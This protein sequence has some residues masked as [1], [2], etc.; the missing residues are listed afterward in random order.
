M[1]AGNEV[2]GWK[3]TRPSIGLRPT[4]PIR[5]DSEGSTLTLRTKWSWWWIVLGLALTRSIGR[6]LSA[7]LMQHRR[8]E[9]PLL[10]LHWNPPTRWAARLSATIVEKKNFRFL[11]LIERPCGCN[12]LMFS[13]MG[14]KKRCAFALSSKDS[15]FSVMWSAPASD[16]S[17]TVDMQGKAGS[18]RLFSGKTRLKTKRLTMTHSPPNAAFE[19]SKAWPQR[20]NLDVFDLRISKRG[21]ILRT[22]LSHTASSWIKSSFD[23]YWSGISSREK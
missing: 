15:A 8:Q 7:C 13:M 23:R 1:S 4:T 17:R 12:Q 2:T 6:V 10:K 9:K 14:R 11:P 3:P 5:G 18:G 19:P 20:N 16:A 22:L 21:C